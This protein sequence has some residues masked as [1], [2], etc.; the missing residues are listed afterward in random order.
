MPQLHLLCSDGKHTSRGGCGG[1]GGERGGGRALRGWGGE[2][3]RHAHCGRGG[4][5]GGGVAARFESLD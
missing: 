3:R 2:G 1:G 4:R 5:G